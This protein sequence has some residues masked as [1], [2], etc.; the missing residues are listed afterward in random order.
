MKEKIK[1]NPLRIVIY[2]FGLL[3]VCTGI[4][5]STKTGLGISTVTAP[6]FAFSEA[7]GINISVPIFTLYA[8]M[9][10][11]QFIIRGKKN[12]RW[13]DLLQFPVAIAQSSFVGWFSEQIPIHFDLLWQNLLLMVAGVVLTGI[14]IAM[15][16]DM[17]IVPNPPDGLTDAIS[18]KTGKDMGLIKNFEDAACV[19]VA[20]FI[21]L[22]FNG[23]LI[24]VGL[25]TVFAMIFLGRTVYVFNRFFKTKVQRAAGLI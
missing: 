18:Q 5:L 1:I 10:I 7:F 13:R 16:V 24:S 11:A 25:G 6:S 21:D 14:G 15:M 23:K 2:L 12:R 3:L 4:S 17:Q 9:I 20:L 19:A 22:T 8:M